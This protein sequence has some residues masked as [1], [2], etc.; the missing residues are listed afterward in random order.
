MLLNEVY[1]DEFYTKNLIFRANIAFELRQFQKSDSIHHA[2]ESQF[3]K[4]DNPELEAYT[5]LARANQF[6]QQDR[7]LDASQK[8][9]KVLSLVDT[10]FRNQL[11][12]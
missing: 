1:D 7:H 3:I 6:E 12:R 5:Y 10:T 9:E 8:Y 4:Y 11:K 2:L